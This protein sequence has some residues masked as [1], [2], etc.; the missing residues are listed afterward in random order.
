MSQLSQDDLEAIRK[1]IPPLARERFDAFLDRERT[2]TGQYLGV[3][4]L[5]SNMALHLPEDDESTDLRSSLEDALDDAKKV[6]PRLKWR[7]T[8]NRFDLDLIDPEDVEG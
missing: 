7:R 5:A 2:L 3:L 6:V 1:A 8:L 4:Q